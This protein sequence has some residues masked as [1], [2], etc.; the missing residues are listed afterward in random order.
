MNK[1]Y[2]TFLV[3]YPMVLFVVA[4]F[5]K[6]STVHKADDILQ[7]LLLLLLF[8]QNFFLFKNTQKQTT[9]TLQRRCS[10]VRRTQV[11]TRPLHCQ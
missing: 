4:V 6:H 3:C 2:C 9:W 7:P 5:E 10:G 1:Q 11:W 8:F